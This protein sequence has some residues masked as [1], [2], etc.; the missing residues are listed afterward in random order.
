[1]AFFTFIPCIAACAALW[2]KSLHTPPVTSP[3]DVSQQDS[4]VIQEFRVVEY[5]SYCLQL[6]FDWK[7]K[8]DHDRIR[9]LV[10]DGG[11]I[12]KRG[13]P[14]VDWDYAEPGIIIP[15]HIKIIRLNIGKTPETIYESTV[16]TKAM[17]AAGAGHFVRKVITIDLKPGMYRV[18]ANTIKDSPE[19]KGTMSHL[20]IDTHWQ[21]KFLPDAVNIKERQ[22]KK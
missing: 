22:I 19:F 14:P 6:Q 1:M 10:G 7:N 4:K 9:L 11:L 15:V 8:D 13:V 12:S 20:L 17:E 16:D 21:L 2:S 18:E 5:R 3:F